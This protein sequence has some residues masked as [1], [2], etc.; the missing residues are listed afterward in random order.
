MTEQT[1]GVSGIIRF[2]MEDIFR[3][4]IRNY[5]NLELSEIYYG[6]NWTNRILGYFDNLGRLM[7]YY[8]YYE[9][10]KYDLTWFEN[11]NEPANTEPP[12]LHV[13]SENDDTRF[14]TALLGKVKKSP[15]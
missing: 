11:Y 4:F 1:E 6:T 13:E 12:I 14:S 7:G 10:N 3:A 9:W 15:K 8:V 5:G 2:S